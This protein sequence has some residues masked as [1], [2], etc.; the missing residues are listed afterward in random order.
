MAPTVAGAAVRAPPPPAVPD[1]TAPA[2]AIAAGRLIRAPSSPA[3]PAVG[4]GLPGRPALD[5]R[6]RNI[7][8]RAQLGEELSDADRA[9]LRGGRKAHD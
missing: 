3:P 6:C 2:P 1:S 7:L 9:Y 4:R 8:G 5:Q